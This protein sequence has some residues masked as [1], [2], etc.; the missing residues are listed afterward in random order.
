MNRTTTVSCEQLISS[1]PDFF[2]SL[3]GDPKATFNRVSSPEDAKTDSVC[4]CANPKAIAQGLAS[5]APVLVVPAKAAS[6]VEP[7]RGN[8]TLI[9][10]ANVERAMAT[11]INKYFLETPYKDPSITGV[12]PTAMIHESAEIGPNSR[13]GPHAFIGAGSKLGANVFIG[14]NAVI[15]ANVTIGEG[16][17]IHPLAYVGHS[18][19]I[20]A[21]CELLPNST[22]ATEGFGYAHDEKGNHYRIPHQ[23]IVVLEDGVQ[24]GAN[25]TIDRATFLETRVGAGTII[26]NMCH[27]AHNCKVGRNSVLV[28]KFGMAGSAKAGANFVAGGDTNVIGHIEIC[29]NVTIAGMS[30]VTKSISEPGQY[31][32]YPLVSLQQYLK[33]KAAMANL[34]EMR[35]QLS[36]LVKK[37]LPEQAE[38]EN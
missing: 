4:F 22:V 34:P 9:F 6:E 13:I 1:L 21:R 23:G 31:G 19:R 24:L 33:T 30:G 14:A 5:V 32:G 25:S 7:K 38:S 18:S 15:E 29:D 3:S 20:G 27:I 28:A 35:K 16:T 2:K 37:F 10:A 12:H 26:D 36:A 8:K 17:V 11:T